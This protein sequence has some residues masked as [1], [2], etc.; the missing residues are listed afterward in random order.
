VDYNELAK[1][2]DFSLMSEYVCM[3]TADHLEATTAFREKRQ[4][5]FEGR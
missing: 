2:M 5:K 1:I 4:P 3:T